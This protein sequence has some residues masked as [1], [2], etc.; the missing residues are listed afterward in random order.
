MKLRYLEL[1]S[2]I[3]VPIACIMAD[4]RN[5]ILMPDNS[6]SGLGNEKVLDQEETFRWDPFANDTP[7][8]FPIDYS[9]REFAKTFGVNSSKLHEKLIENY[10]IKDVL[11]RLPILHEDGELYQHKAGTNPKIPLPL[12]AGP[13]LASLFRQTKKTG[14]CAGYSS[15]QDLPKNM[16]KFLENMFQDLCE[17]VLKQHE[18]GDQAEKDENAFCRHVLFA[19]EAFNRSVLHGLWKDQLE[20]RFK[21]LQALAEHAPVEEQANVLV[22]CLLSID[23]GISDLA[24]WKGTPLQTLP[25]ERATLCELLRNLLVNRNHEHK[26]ESN[27]N[28]DLAAYD[29]PNIRFQYNGKEKTLQ[30]AFEQLKDFRHT[31]NNAIKDSARS[32]YL[33][34]L[35]RKTETPAFEKGYTDIYDYLTCTI[36]PEDIKQLESKIRESMKKQC[37]NVIKYCTADDFDPYGYPR[38]DFSKELKYIGALINNIIQTHMSK[39][40]SIFDLTLKIIRDYHNYNKINE[41]DAIAMGLALSLYYNAH[42][43]E[44]SGFPIDEIYSIIAGKAVLRLPAHSDCP[45][46]NFYYQEA[47]KFADFFQVAWKFLCK[48][49]DD[50]IVFGSDHQLLDIGKTIQTFSEQTQDAIEFFG[51]EVQTEQLNDSIATGFGSYQKIISNPMYIYS[52]KEYLDGSLPI[53]N[54]ILVQV[55]KRIVEDSVPQVLNKILYLSSALQSQED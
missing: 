10:L 47:C 42:S 18:L 34:Y 52:F 21:Q 1:F 8:L 45:K 7:T 51:V 32:A 9:A 53:L 49:S 23:Q 33:A 17:E 15:E 24:Q 28:K 11:G 54:G 19:N 37:L 43:E 44:M 3:N 16:D 14:Y 35:A 22:G 50:R 30:N 36:F 55:L 29:V 26:K 40:W 13:F 38:L 25:E 6:S 31:Q 2:F 5:V 27:Y 4:E 41:S 12:E 39:Q 46:V 48:G 20:P